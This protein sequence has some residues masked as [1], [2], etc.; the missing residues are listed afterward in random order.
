M[1]GLLTDRY[2]LAMVG[3]Y[4]RE[5]IAERRAVFELSVRALPPQRRFLLVAG[6]DRAVRYLQTLRFTEAEVEYLCR[7]P[8][9]ADVMTDAMAGF[10]LGFQF[11]GD[12]DVMPEGEV[13][14]A[15]EPLVRVEGTLAEGQLVETFLLGILNAE[16]RVA[17]KAAR[18]VIAA[19]GRP[20][21]EFGARR[22]DPLGAPHAA[23]AAYLAG[24]V[25]SSCEAAGMEFGVPV[26]G[27]CSHG[28]V[29]A[30][31][32]E[33]EA[34]AFSAFGAAFPGGTTLLIDTYD[35]R[36]GA[37]RA[38]AAG[39]GVRAVRIDSGDLEVLARDVRSIL[40]AAGRPDVQLLASDDLDEHRIAALVQAGAPYDGFGVGTAIVLTPDAPS[41]GAIYK[42]VSVHDR[43]EVWVPVG[44]R[45]PA[46][47]SYGG[48]K[49][50]YR[51]RHADGTLREDIVGS[52]DPSAEPAAVTAGEA[53][54]VPMLR[55]GKLVRDLPDAH[56]AT[57][58]ARARAA[59]ALAS[60]PVGLRSLGEAVGGAHS[61]S[62]SA[63]IKALTPHEP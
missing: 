43:R 40:D 55:R 33:G 2:A 26:A 58:E 15:T 3:A 54:L 61:V 19:A 50:V 6:V 52:A 27:T 44:K 31:V 48:A 62:Y 47:P 49:Q 46:K 5:G 32:D 24:C 20:V 45:S 9:L 60:L 35:T 11:R 53:L 34:M 17:S 25:A 41:L 16:T 1:L 21:Y 51:L 22:A 63:A 13:A 42:L 39:P 18:V 23:R 28:Y 14:F 30:H 8:G 59:G 38:A 4:L 37:L 57:A 29:L 36:R 10:L 7:A 56:T 12:V